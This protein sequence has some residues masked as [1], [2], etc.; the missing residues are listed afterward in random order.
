[1]FNVFPNLV[2]VT[3]TLISKLDI[4][5]RRQLKMLRP[6]ILKS[7]A[8]AAEFLN[9]PAT[10]ISL[11]P[12]LNFASDK[13]LITQHLNL[14]V[15]PAKHTPS[16]RLSISKLIFRRGDPRLEAPHQI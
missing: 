10:N 4:R 8:A 14:A 2:R 1:M 15:T 11:I 5:P 6:E 7:A 12:I 3:L 9:L 16:A 13:C